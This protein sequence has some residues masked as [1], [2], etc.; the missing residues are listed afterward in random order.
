MKNIT[1]IE[2]QVI[3]GKKHLSVFRKQMEILILKEFLKLLN[4]IQENSKKIFM[5]INTNSNVQE[6]M[7]LFLV[8]ITGLIMNFQPMKWEKY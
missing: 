7:Y 8:L 3:K 5:V 1:N 4:L 2:K 6:L